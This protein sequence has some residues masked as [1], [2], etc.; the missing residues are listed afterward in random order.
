MHQENGEVIVSNSK[1]QEITQP[2]HKDFFLKEEKLIINRTK[3]KVCEVIIR[4]VIETD[5]VEVPIRR[6]KLIVEQVGDETKQLAEIKLSEDKIVGVELTE[7]PQGKVGY[8]ATGEYN[9]VQTAK[10][11]LEA[12]TPQ[13]NHGCVRVRLEILVDN[14]ELHKTYQEIMNNT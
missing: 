8:A 6:E 4:K 1:S 5:V 13:E 9:S 11:I 3:R 2:Q 14:R 7:I 10:K 12:I